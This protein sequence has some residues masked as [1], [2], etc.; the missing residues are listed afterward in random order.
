LGAEVTGGRCGSH[1]Q[2]FAHPDACGESAKTSCRHALPASR[3]QVSGSG[4]IQPPAQ[5]LHDTVTDS[6]DGP[7]R[8][9]PDGLEGRGHRSGPVTAIRN[10]VAVFVGVLGVA[11]LLLAQGDTTPV[12]APATSTTSAVA[13]PAT[14][15]PSTT[16]TTV[17]DSET[18]Q[19]VLPDVDAMLIAAVGGDPVRLVTW[20]SSG[21][22]RILPIPMWGGPEI[23]V[24]RS[25]RYMAFLGPALAGEDSALYV[26]DTVMWHPL[27]VQVSSF[28]WHARDAGRI[29]WTGGGLL[30]SGQVNPEGGFRSLECLVDVEGR[31]LGFDDAGYLLADDAGSIVRLGAEG[32]EK[33]RTS[34]DDAMIGSD[35]RVLIVSSK[36]NDGR[37]V[38]DFSVGEPDLNRITPLDW[39]PTAAM[40]EYGFVAWS[41]ASSPPE[42]AFL[43]RLDDNEWQLQRWSIAGRLLSSPTITGRYWNVEWGW[44]GRYLLVPGVDD[45]GTYVIHIYDTDS[46]QHVVLDATDSVQDIHLVRDPNAPFEFDL[47]SLLKSANVK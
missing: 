37:P 41:P 46:R 42:V 2:Y 16:T 28:R 15:P 6:R 9:S 19:A 10:V 24:D 27:A 32:A 3:L 4:N 29:A 14:T 26:G 33:G 13:T 44:S 36:T 47:T 12:T 40:G 39:A 5:R 25:G 45:R 38:N 11:V 43:V 7:A 22:K 30:C 17:P 18:L 34:G 20:P 21:R 8:V 1:V 31:L 23:E 35:G